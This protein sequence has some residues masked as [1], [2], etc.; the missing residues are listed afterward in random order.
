MDLEDDDPSDHD[1]DLDEEPA[2]DPL[3][4]SEDEEEDPEE[5]VYGSGSDP[6]GDGV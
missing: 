3:I 4:P 1:E 5:R 2:D 6:D